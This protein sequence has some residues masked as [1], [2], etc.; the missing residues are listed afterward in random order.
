MQSP[1]S[2]LL[3]LVVLILVAGGILAFAEL[4]Q[5]VRE[6]NTNSFDRSILISMR[7]PADRSDP[8]GPRWLEEMMRDFTA[9]GSHGVVTLLTL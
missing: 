8:L 1:R 3:P 6:G 7:E 2:E 4:A 9:L 5:D